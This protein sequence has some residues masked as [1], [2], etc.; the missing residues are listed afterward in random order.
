M[1]GGHK[2]DGGLGTNSSTAYNSSLNL[3]E[4]QV[5]QFNHWIVT[6]SQTSLICLVAHL[7]LFPTQD[8]I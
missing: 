3:C 5:W 8:C 2:S 1:F 7:F 4:S 6:Y